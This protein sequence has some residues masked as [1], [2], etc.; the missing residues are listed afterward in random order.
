MIKMVVFDMAG[1]TVDE[2]N[3]VYKTLQKAITKAGFPVTL[4]KVLEHGAG[5]E[6]LQAIKDVLASSNHL[7]NIAEIAKPI[8]T[9]FKALLEIAYD[10]EPISTFPG[11]T[12]LFSFLRQKNIKVVLNTG[13][14]RSTALKL[15]GK[16]NWQS[17]MHYDLLVTASE[18][19]RS[20][21]FP[22]MITMAMDKLQIEDPSTV[23]KIGDSAIDIEEGKSANCY[24][25]LGVTT[26]AQTVDQ[27]AVANP[28]HIINALPEIKQLILLNE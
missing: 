25:S 23:I 10:S 19:K 14:D 6:K 15:L 20:R 11:T 24:L 8:Y 27:L 1:T 3:L 13:Y 28:D 4:E 17:G 22:D 16:L 7:E 9:E 5:K 12:E 2:Q 18:V 26:G 21:P